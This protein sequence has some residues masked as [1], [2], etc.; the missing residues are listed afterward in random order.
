[1]SIR[2][3]EREREREQTDIHK[4]K[5]DRHREIWRGE[6]YDVLG[7]TKREREKERREKAKNRQRGEEREI[8]TDER[9]ERKKE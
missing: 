3:R 2:E 6:I 7:K 5:T 1:M 9:R 8:H 4:Y